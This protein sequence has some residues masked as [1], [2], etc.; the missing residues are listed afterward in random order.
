MQALNDRERHKEE[1]QA[2]YKCKNFKKALQRHIQEAIEDKYLKLL[3]NDNT[4]LIQE[5]IPDVLDYL[6]D[7]Y[8]KVPSEEVK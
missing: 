8:G 3:V 1:K 4:Q 5:D 6:F 7:L 2:Y